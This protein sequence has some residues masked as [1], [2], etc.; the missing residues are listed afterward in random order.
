MSL[1][2][3][4]SAFVLQ[5][6]TT[7]ATA[8]CPACSCPSERVRSRYQRTLADLAWADSDVQL[9]VTARKFACRNP[10]CPRQVFTEPLPALAARYAR[11]TVRL[12][13]TLRS[14]GLTLGGN[15]GARAA[16]R[17]HTVASPSTLLRLAH[18][19]PLPV[20]PPPTA[21]GI[22]EWAWRRSHRYGSI[23]VDL[24]SHQV[25]DLLPDRSSDSVASWFEA[26]PEVQVV[27]RD[28]SEGF[29]DGIRRGAPQAVQVVDRFHLVQNLRE[30][31]ERTLL[32][33]RAIL[34]TVATLTAQ[35]VAATAD[36]V[37]AQTQYRG[38]R[39]CAQTAKQRLEVERQQ[40]LAP[41]VAAYEAVHELRTQHV[42]VA[43]IARVVGVSRQTVY[44]YLGQSSP[45]GPKRAQRNPA[46]RLLTPYIPHLLRRWREGCRESTMLW[47]ELQ[48]LGAR[49]SA[50]TVSR[51]V[52]ELRRAAEAGQP[53]EQAVSPFTREQGPSPRAVSFVLV[54]P[55]AKRTEIEQ[56]FVEQLKK[57]DPA[58][59][60]ADRLAQAFLRLVRE[61]RGAELGAWIAEVQ[62]SGV[63]ALARFAV[64]LTSDQTA[65][66]A[67]LT[68]KWSNGVTE[69]QV[70]R[71]K[72]LK[73]QSYGRAG[74]ELL[75]QQMLHA[76]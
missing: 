69:G 14:I 3:T 40:R 35:A 58:I 41:R 75:R 39:Q 65:V 9:F 13:T 16:R 53:P 60:E 18:T 47:R 2:R 22:D 7:A 57:L 37:P 72:L 33:R 59:A 10:D 43:Q 12:T 6:R 66:Q 62:G 71:L 68:E 52:T 24:K 54:R 55:R 64:G 46:Y 5:L 19:A 56:S 36:I 21:V 51:F 31:L 30:A 20:T 28:R 70:N 49:V 32:D 11:K 76:S 74:I 50:R 38:R 1:T 67:G 73:R 45:P 34:L 23:L 25:V 17:Q 61:R 42:P 63:E 27:S 4:E 48:E 15:A 44:A 26:H 8:A 29:A